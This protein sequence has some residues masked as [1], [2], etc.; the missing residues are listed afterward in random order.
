MLYCLAVVWPICLKLILKGG[1]PG[2]LLVEV[3][4]VAAL[5]AFTLLVLQVVLAGRFRSLD[6]PFGLDRLMRFHK[7]MAV[8]AGILLLTHPILI[9]LGRGNFS[10]LTS[11]MRWFIL[12]G[13]TALAIVVGMIAF[14]LLFGQIGVD[15]NTW[16]FLHKGVIFIIVLGFIHSIWVGA[17]LTRVP[18]LVLWSALLALAAGIFV[19][20]NGYVPIWGKRRFR[21]SDVRQETHDT[22][23]LRL[24]PADG[25]PLR[26][27]PGQFMFLRLVRP[28][29]RS[30]THPFTISASALEPAIVE[31]TIKKS[32]DFTDTIGQT[33]P[34]DRALIEG[35][36][37]RF[38]LMYFDVERF[39]FL[40]GGVGITPIMSMLRYL[41]DT[42]DTR[43][44]TLIYGNKTAVD[45][46]FAAELA[47]LP[48]HIRVVHVL[49]RPASG[50]PGLTGH[51]T[52]AMIQEC[53]GE[54]LPRSHFFLCGPAAM[55]EAVLRELK[56]VHADRRRIHY[57][58]FAI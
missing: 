4:R 5:A 17:D 26:R 12:V 30:E 36:F 27:H 7:G 16:R 35:P 51:I 32:G 31:A 19:W 45:I 42:G 21:V 29:R 55:M 13:K 15:Y 38:S 49:S 11:D 46:V 43:P 1:L 22:Y 23:T 40:A 57:E 25:R 10:L 56:E 18:M 20:R 50:W 28:G 24:E 34:G 41:R 33:H 44:A 2:R 52:A 3:G 39:V 37:G 47:D 8:L 58:R 54:D 53:V 9:S 6:A 48:A 14:S